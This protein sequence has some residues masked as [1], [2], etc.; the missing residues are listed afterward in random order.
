MKKCFKCGESKD[1][2]EFYVHKQMDD[3]HLG[4]CKVCTIKDNKI[5]NGK[6]ERKCLLCGNKFRTTLHETKRRGGGGKYCSRKCFMVKFVEMAKNHSE[7]N[8]PNWKGNKVKKE[9]LHNWVQRVLGKPNKC[10]HCLK[11]GFGIHQ[12]DWANKSHKYLR[13]KS[14]WIRL[15]RKCHMKYDGHSATRKITMIK[16]YGNLN[17]RTANK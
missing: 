14:D 5:S 4:K 7:E 3:G 15:C 10:E 1:I 16:R 9:G 13:E 11:T 17:T 12:I 2:S 8:S 6:I